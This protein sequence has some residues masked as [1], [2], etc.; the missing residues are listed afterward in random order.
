VSASGSSA[1]SG[2]STALWALASL[3]NLGLLTG[4]EASRLLSSACK[5]ALSTAH[6]LIRAY[7]AK[8]ADSELGRAYVTRMAQVTRWQKPAEIALDP[9]LTDDFLQRILRQLDW[10]GRGRAGGGRS[11]R[12]SAESPRKA[13]FFRRS[14]SLQPR[15]CECRVRGSLSWVFSVGR[16]SATRWLPA[17]FD[18]IWQ[19][20]G[21]EVNAT[22]LDHKD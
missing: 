19:S 7:V 21:A 22:R 11:G 10:A 18:T 16:R 14:V 9:V 5:S 15:G 2:A 12:R 20:T 4:K 6:A 1:A 8:G 17:W 13:W 3:R